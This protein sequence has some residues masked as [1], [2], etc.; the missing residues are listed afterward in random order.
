MDLIKIHD[1]EKTPVV[2]YA[3]S[4]IGGRTE[5][6]DSFSFSDTPLGFLV[7]VCD[8]MGGG[9]GGKAASSIAV[10]EI[11][12]RVRDFVPDGENKKSPADVVKEAV[13]HANQAVI[14]ACDEHS[15]LK[16]MGSTATVLLVSEQAAIIAHVGDSRVYQLRGGQKVF[17]TFDHSVVFDMVRQ[18][19]ITE[20]QARLSAQSNVITRA[21]GVKADVEVEVNVVPYEAGDRFML[22]T[23]GIHGVMP[24]RNLVKLASERHNALGPVVDNI[25]TTADEIGRRDGGG[26]DNLTLAIIQVKN[27]SILKTKMPKRVKKILMLLGVVCALSITLNV[28][29][30]VISEKEGDKREHATSQSSPAA[31]PGQPEAIP[32]KDTL[33]NAG[34][35]GITTDPIKAEEKEQQTEQK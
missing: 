32:H 23:D 28:V 17:R 25:A 16:G 18:K 8:G 15:E 20:E 2:G 12:K 1:S 34:L 5:N 4:R 22:C 27:N 10:T 35:K 33:G 14:D 3:E 7:T 11:V 30:L 13:E 9:P 31:T 29:Q 21:L 19:I 26:H 6:Q 24:E